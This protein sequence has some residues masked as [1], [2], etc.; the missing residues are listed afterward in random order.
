MAALSIVIYSIIFFLP[1][2][3]QFRPGL[4]CICFAY[5]FYVEWKKFLTCIC[6]FNRR[7]IHPAKAF[8]CLL[9]LSCS[10]F[11]FAAYGNWIQNPPEYDACVSFGQSYNLDLSDS[12]VTVS[13]TNI[14]YGAP[15]THN[16]FKN[17]CPNTHS[18][19]FPST[20]SGHSDKEKNLKEVSLEDSGSRHSGSLGVE[21]TQD[22]QQA[23]NKSWSSDYGMFKL[24]NGAIVSCSLKSREGINDVSSF[25]TGSSHKD[26]DDIS[27][28]GGSLHKQKT[29]HF[30]PKNSEISESSSFSPNVRITPT[31]L[32]WGQ[33]DVYSPSVAFITVENTHNDGILH[34]YEPFS[35]DVQFYPCNFSEVSLGPGESALISFIFFP[36]FLGL[37]SA[38]LI[39]QTS[40]GGFFIEAKGYA[41]ESTYGIQPM[42]GLEISPGGR[43]SK[44]FS[45]FNSFDETLYVDE[46]TAWISV[47]LGHNSVETEAICSINDFHAFDNLFFPTAKDRLVV[48]SDHIGSPVVAIRPHRNWEVSPHSSG[49]LIE[50]DISVGLEGKIVGA[51]CLHVLRSSQDKADT[52]VVPIEAAVIS[53]S[54]HDTVGMYVSA[55]LE[56][57]TPCD[58][59]ETVI[60]ISIRNDA[61]YLS[62]F[63]KVVEVADTE[64]FHIKYMEGLLLFPNTVTQIAIIY[65]SNLH[66]KLHDLPPEVSDLRDN[67]KLLILTNDS[68][69]PQIEIQCEDI[70]YMCFGHQRLSSVGLE[71][72]PGYS[73]SGDLRAGYVGRSMQVPP[74]VKVC[75]VFSWFNLQFLFYLNQFL[76]LFWGLGYK[77][78][79]T[80]FYENVE[81]QHF[82]SP[83][84]FCF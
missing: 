54:A 57:L 68:T 84:P 50:I 64:I 69:S 75:R 8:N 24:L 43:L 19:C 44:N 6:G 10:F 20:L 15:R 70:L 82:P 42:L 7:L 16:S 36:R 62:S 28:C 63:V 23:S 34:L 80:E 46:I 40:Y 73:E 32:D 76:T 81:E 27:S 13:D 67:C 47:S 37:S 56:A 39:L 2:F 9:V 59:G 14:G 4:C 51:F 74:H 77:I 55:T 41:T 21:L 26:E 60:T 22:N 66:I 29:T 58:G 79:T 12:V 65:C 30:L 25:R 48:K 35:T 33:K 31:V 53:N 49:T 72:K 17:V 5:I 11:C 45:L 52:V 78:L 18:F 83:H 3:F 61:P 38:H 71:H 1:F